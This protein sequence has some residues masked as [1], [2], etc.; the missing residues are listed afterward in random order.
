MVL[1]VKRASYDVRES[2]PFVPEQT[3][4]TLPT[5]VSPIVS[6]IQA[7]WETMRRV[8]IEGFSKAP[9]LPRDHKGYLGFVDD[10]YKSVAYHSLSIEGY[11][12]NPASIERVQR[13][14]WDLEHHD[15]DRKNRDALAAR[16]Y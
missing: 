6:C 9:G 7:I 12:V 3:F 16:G 14:D 2:D 11:I 8:V 10:I 13:G 5:A 1:H 15:D 4:G